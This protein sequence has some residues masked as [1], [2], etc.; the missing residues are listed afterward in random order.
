MLD[1]GAKQKGRD[2][3]AIWD[4]RQHGVWH[5]EKHPLHAEVTHITGVGVGLKKD[6]EGAE[7]W[8]LGG[9]WE[10]CPPMKRE[11]G[12]QNRESWAE[13]GKAK[14]SAEESQLREFEFSSKLSPPSFSASLCCL[15]YVYCLLIER[16]PR[17]SQLTKKTHRHH[18]QW[19]SIFR[20]YGL[21]LFFFST[22]HPFNLL[23]N[24]ALL[25]LDML[26]T[27]SLEK[28]RQTTQVIINK[29]QQT[30]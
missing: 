26:L 27:Q 7:N 3:G 20:I 21:L 19:G 29:P 23:F 25:A 24:P 1:K 9:K 18:T 2:T 6:S 11:R 17:L 5:F 13:N 12:K 30:E 16:L 22:Q 4:Q 14:E 8:G 10:Q 15:L 28:D